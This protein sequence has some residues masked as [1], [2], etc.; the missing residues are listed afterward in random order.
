MNTQQTPLWLTE[1]MSKTGLTLTTINYINGK[2]TVLPQDLSLEECIVIY[3]M[4]KEVFE[5]TTFFK[6]WIQNFLYD[7]DRK[8]K[9]T[10]LQKIAKENEQA[11][12]L[13]LSYAKTKDIIFVCENFSDFWEL[14]KKTKSKQ[15]KE[16]ILVVL[17]E[18]V[19][20]LS[21]RDRLLAYYSLTKNFPTERIIAETLISA[22][23]LKNP[24]DARFMDRFWGCKSN[25]V[26]S[27]RDIARLCKNIEE[28]KTTQIDIDVLL[29]LYK[30]TNYNK[31]ILKLVITKINEEEKS[32][33]CNHLLESIKTE[34]S[35]LQNKSNKKQ[36][37]NLKKEYLPI[38]YELFQK[39]VFSDKL[40]E[41]LFVLPIFDP[42]NEMLRYIM[43]RLLTKYEVSYQ[44]GLTY[45]KA[46]RI[47]AYY[48]NDNVINAYI[49]TIGQHKYKIFEG[50]VE[51]FT[52]CGQDRVIEKA[53]EFCF[54]KDY[55]MYPNEIIYMLNW[56]KEN[57]STL[58]ESAITKISDNKIIE[59]LWGTSSGADFFKI[60]DHF[61]V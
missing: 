23:L 16:I 44:F 41:L 11:K 5:K 21:D 12:N 58:Y 2:N 56:L 48:Q 38:V 40:S 10:E 43:D 37:E 1:S 18:I 7:P 22:F 51:I 60:L 53:F 24:D 15:E 32:H 45:D 29:S 59:G 13:M 27:T 8:F 26:F 3:N 55:H 47:Y 35:D 46:K 33:Y 25:F 30:K 50:A 14:F 54:S 42:S 20:E 28:K 6:K 49:K 36:L 19:V 57:N 52:L 39:D 31:E 17:R 34:I 4:K 61:V 9:K